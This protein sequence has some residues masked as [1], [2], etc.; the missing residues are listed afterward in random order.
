MRA[1]IIIG[2]FG[3]VSGCQ[4]GS[5]GSLEISGSEGVS[6]RFDRFLSLAR[7]GTDV[8]VVG[9]RGA[10]ISSSDGGVTWSRTDLRVSGTVITP[11][12]ISVSACPDGSFAAL[13]AERHVWTSVDGLGGWT[14]QVLPTTENPMAI[15]C[16]AAGAYWVVGSFTTLWSSSDQGA[17]WHEQSFDEDLIFTTVQFPTP[18]EG[19]SEERRV[20]EA[21]RSRWSP[22]H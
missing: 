16:D 21:C 12:L 8:V 4:G 14:A 13:D 2:L 1:F 17:S 11:S 7:S 9:A 19:R 22:Y 5:D 3:L 20:G 10:V 15:T 6:G 18:G